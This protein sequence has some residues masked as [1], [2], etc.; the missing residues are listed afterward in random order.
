MNGHGQRHGKGHGHGHGIGVFLPITNMAQYSFRTVCVRDII[1]SLRHG[2]RINAC[3][4][5][6][7]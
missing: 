6:P 7:Q 5:T 3:G 4:R 2:Q 1:E